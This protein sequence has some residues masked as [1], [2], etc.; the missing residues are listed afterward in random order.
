LQI[1]TAAADVIVIEDDEDDE[2]AGKHTPGSHTAVKEQKLD[3]NDV[4]NSFRLLP[5]KVGKNGRYQILYFTLDDVLPERERWAR[6]VV[7][8]EVIR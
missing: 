7:T 6:R 8:S 5:K 2:D 1:D 4:L 3:P